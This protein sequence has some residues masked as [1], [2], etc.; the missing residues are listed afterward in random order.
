PDGLQADGLATA[1]FV[2]G[3]ER[4]LKFLN[5]RTGIQAILVTGNGKVLTTN[6]IGSEVGFERR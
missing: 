3:P 4:G 1:A 2:M 5:S 6:G